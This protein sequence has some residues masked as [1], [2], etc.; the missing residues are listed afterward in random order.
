MKTITQKQFL[1]QTN[2]D[3]KLCRAVIQQMGGWEQFTSYAP[4]VANHGIDVG[5]TGFIYYT[6]TEP[7][8]RRH[9]KLIAQLASEQAEDMGVGVH[10][11]IRGF[12]CFKRDKLSDA[13]IGTALYAG[14]NTEDG[15]NL[16]NALA[17]YAGEEVCRAY[18]DMMEQGGEQ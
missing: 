7:F 17:W 14:K 16:L 10:E 18:N 4:D 1:N 13:E 9:R 15:P 3:P 11:M 5:F 12:N 2:I 8:A 6:E